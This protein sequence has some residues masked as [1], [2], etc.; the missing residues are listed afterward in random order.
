MNK[1]C[2]ECG[3]EMDKGVAKLTGFDVTTRYWICTNDGTVRTR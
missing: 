1:K 3:K 2:P